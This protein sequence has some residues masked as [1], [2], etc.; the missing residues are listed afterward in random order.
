[1]LGQVQAV[2]GRVT[3]DVEIKGD[4]WQNRM[5]NRYPNRPHGLSYLVL[6]GHRSTWQRGEIKKMTM[7]ART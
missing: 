3:Q 4:Q 5:T 7:I 2:W 6:A 1:M